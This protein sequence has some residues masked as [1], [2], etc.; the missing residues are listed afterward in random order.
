MDKGLVNIFTALVA[1]AA[2]LKTLEARRQARLLAALLLIIAALIMFSL[3]SQ[4]RSALAGQRKFPYFFTTMTLLLIL[5]YILSRTRYYYTAG[6]IALGTL[7]LLPFGSLV[8]SGVSYSM[9]VGNSLMWLA[10]PLLL[11]SVLV[12]VRDTA[13]L[14]AANLLGILACPQVVPQI[15]YSEVMPLFG[16]VLTIAAL[17]FITNRHR[18]VLENARRTE[19]L[20]RN[21]ELQTARN[22]LEQHRAQLQVANAQLQ[23]EIAEREKAEAA[24]ARL[25]QEIIA[26]Q[27]ETLKKL[28]TPIIP[29]IDR[30]I[31]LPLIGHVDAVRAKDITRALLAGISTHRAKV[32]ILDITGVP[33]V[34][35]GVAAHLDK[36]IQAARLKG[37]RTII[38][39][40]SD[41]VAEALVDLGLDWSKLE[42]RRDL[43]TGLLAALRSLGIN[44]NSI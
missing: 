4:F 25:Q 34:D 6:I 33:L 38:T 36:A 21:R 18:V 13:L 8:T 1:P 14:A 31:V 27:R 3:F 9:S 22:S 29:V 11:S 19:I 41:A 28:S 24:R 5:A 35:S 7:S 44:P 43:Q 30:V 16:F 37:A 10:L 39:G 42:T 17:I 2:V 12:K 15:S 32:V 23:Q 20:D 26:T 40:I